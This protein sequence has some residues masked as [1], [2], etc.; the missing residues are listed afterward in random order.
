M[1]ERTVG[2]IAWRPTGD[3]QGR[4]YFYSL[5]TS[6]IL[7]RRSCN[8]LPIPDEAIQNIEKMSQQRYHGYTLIYPDGTVILVNGNADGSI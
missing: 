1:M 8:E 7:N 3:Q 6:R 5:L 2:D 4:Y